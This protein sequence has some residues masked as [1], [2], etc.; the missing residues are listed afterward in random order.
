MSICTDYSLVIPIDRQH[1]HV[2]TPVFSSYSNMFRLF[3]NKPTCKMVWKR[4]DQ[5]V[6]YAFIFH[7]VGLGLQYEVTEDLTTTDYDIFVNDT[8]EEVVEFPKNYATR[9]YHK[10][11]TRYIVHYTH[12]T[13]KVYSNMII[14]GML[15]E[16][17]YI[18]RYTFTPAISSQFD[19]TLPD[20][21]V[22]LELDD[23]PIEL[24]NFDNR[25]LL[26]Q[27]EFESNSRML[28]VKQR[29]SMIQHL[30]R[31]KYTPTFIDVNDKFKP[32]QAFFKILEIFNRE[33]IPKPNSVLFLAEAPGM[34][35]VALTELFKNDFT[36]NANS[37]MGVGTLLEDTYGIIE[38]TKDKWIFGD[39]ASEEVFQRCTTQ[40]Y[41]VVTSDLGMDIQVDKD[42]VLAKFFY[43]VVRIAIGCKAKHVIVKVFLP[44]RSELSIMSIRMLRSHYSS[45]RYIKTSLN[46]HSDELYIYASNHMDNHTM[47]SPQGLYPERHSHSEIVN[48]LCKIHIN[49][50]QRK[51]KRIYLRTDTTHEDRLKADEFLKVINWV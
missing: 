4:G 30:K 40:T 18:S 2:Y 20:T 42:E 21:Y 23:N 49:A 13:D 11:L 25:L 15:G 38:N 9:K 33:N 37:Y 10:G 35:I 48:R 36:W 26:P 43:A 8:N 14:P 50:L 44:L 27:Y 1:K 17:Q 7:R 51:L 46:L 47:A 12:L 24:N 34:F 16:K 29:S 22:S 3:D 19:P 28:Q 31:I 41:D 32:S 45:V 5:D 6:K 39:V